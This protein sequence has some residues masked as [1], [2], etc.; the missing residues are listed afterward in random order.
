[1]RLGYTVLEFSEDADSG[2]APE[3]GKK[4]RAGKTKIMA[5]KNAA[6]GKEVTDSRKLISA[7]GRFCEGCSAVIDPEEFEEGAAKQIDG[8]F[9]CP[10]CVVIVEEKGISPGNV[11]GYRKWKEQ[12]K[13]ASAD[14]EETTRGL[15]PIE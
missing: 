4:K 12:E 1:M 6:M 10:E 2:D 13:S 14:G 8:L 9:L 7:K 11:A 15:E 5:A 3:P